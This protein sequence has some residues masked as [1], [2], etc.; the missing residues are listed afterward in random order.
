ME[1]LNFNSSS[2]SNSTQRLYF[3]YQK[4]KLASS[5]YLGEYIFGISNPGANKIN[6][7]YE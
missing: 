3:A 7:I 2:I 5:D 4:G 6:Y 1:K